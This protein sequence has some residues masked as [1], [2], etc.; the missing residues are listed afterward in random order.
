MSSP[1]FD[2][3]PLSPLRK[4]IATR[5][6]EATQAIPHYRVSMD[7]NMVN[8][9]AL[10][11]LM[12]QGCPAERIS[13]NDV[14][15]K[16]CA[17]TLIERPELNIQLVGDEIHR[18]HQADI[19]VVVAVPGGLSTPIIRAADTKTVE[20][21]SREVRSLTDRATRNRLKQSEV[22]GGTFSIS[23][24]GMYGVERFDAVINP[25]Q[26]AILAIG[27]IRAC[28]ISQNDSVVSAAMMT[29]TLALDHRVIDGATGATFLKCLRGKLEH[30]AGLFATGRK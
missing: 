9:L 5:T 29:A 16:A 26:C 19:S 1:A 21:I 27:A 4:A 7:I 13:I 14:V 8:V 30:P 15:I 2:V 6:T 25:P 24:L 12:N 10:R 28:P 22:L 3:V 18:Y 17:T 11:K 23:N 20:D